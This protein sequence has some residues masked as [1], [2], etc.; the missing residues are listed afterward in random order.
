MPIGSRTEK[1]LILLLHFT[2]VSGANETILFPSVLSLIEL[3]KH[4][5]LEK[6]S[7]FARDLLDLLE[8]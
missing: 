1:V 3:R 5:S 7:Y 6:E 4:L 2:L 8:I